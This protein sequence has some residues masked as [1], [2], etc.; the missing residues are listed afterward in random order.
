M[1][2]GEE[3]LTISSILQQV[4]LWFNIF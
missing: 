3:E 4:W 2:L 1:K